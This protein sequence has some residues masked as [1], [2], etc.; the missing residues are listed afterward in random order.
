LRR[1]QRVGGARFRLG[2]VTVM[3]GLGVIWG[4]DRIQVAEALATVPVREVTIASVTQRVRE[5]RGH[6]LILALYRPDSDDPYVVGDVRRWTVQ[7]SSPQV[8]L[9]ALAVGS[10]REAQLL[11]R[12]GEQRGIQRLPPEWLDSRQLETLN[13]VMTELGVRGSVNRS[14]LPLTV[15]FDSNGR[16]T[17]Q[18]QGTVDYLPVLMAAKAA[19]R[20]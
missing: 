13:S 16:V 7:T 11:F 6:V 10:R 19:R 20:E 3:V 1:Q 14:T 17:A 8:E 9:I 12:D 18:W 4:W 2:L 5:A 15:V